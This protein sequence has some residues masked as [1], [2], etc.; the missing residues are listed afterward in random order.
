MTDQ[1]PTIAET[2]AGA[3]APGRFT[4]RFAVIAAIVI[5]ISAIGVSWIQI[6]QTQQQIRQMANLE[7]GQ[8]GRAITNDLWDNAGEVFTHAHLHTPEMHTA[9]PDYME[10]IAEARRLTMGTKVLK[11]KIMDLDGQGQ[12]RLHRQKRGPHDV[13]GG[14]KREYFTDR[15]SGK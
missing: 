7:H 4:R 15:E 6:D 12:Y 13:D 3:A 8:F 14:R 2:T 1:P 9:Q 5:A 11:I 10:L